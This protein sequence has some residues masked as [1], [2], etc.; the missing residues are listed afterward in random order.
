M[1]FLVSRMRLRSKALVPPVLFAIVA[2][3]LTWQVVSRYR[4][5]LVQERRETV[6][7]IVQSTFA[8]LD[9]F[10]A[11]ERRGDMTR[12][13]AQHA[14]RVADPASIRPRQLRRRPG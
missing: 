11:A 9:Y 6:T 3:M 14:A 12:D 2:T 7:A 8:T 13:A 10:A 5:D 4:A 1:L